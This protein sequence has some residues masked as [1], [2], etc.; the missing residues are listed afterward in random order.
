MRNYAAKVSELWRCQN[1]CAMTN[2]R[3]ATTVLISVVSGTCGDTTV[4]CQCAL[5]LYD[6]YHTT[7]TVILQI[8]SMS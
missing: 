1:L 6:N 3:D 2:S 5:P 7:I 8:Y 4:L